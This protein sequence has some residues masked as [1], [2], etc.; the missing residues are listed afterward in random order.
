M[1]YPLP[2]GARITVTCSAS[3]SG[4]AMPTMQM[5][6]DH[7]NIGYIVS[8]DRRA[9]TPS[10]SYSY[11]AGDVA[12]APPLLFHRT[13]PESDA[14]YDRYLIK[15]S[16][17]LLQPLR[18]QADENIIDILY[19]ERVCRF[20]EASR[21]KIRG[22]F[23]EMYEEYS[24]GRSYTELILQGMLSRL[25]T[26]IW[27]E[28]L[29][30]DSA[31]RYPTKLTEPIVESLYFMETHY[32]RSLTLEKLAARAHLSPAY[33]SRLFS[34]QLGK[35]FSEYLAEIRLRHVQTLLARSNKTVTDIAME[36]G[37][38]SGDYLSTQ[39]KKRIGMTPSEYRRMVKSGILSAG[40]TS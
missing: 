27:E 40:S 29:P 11:H 39:F 20:N 1:P 6:T 9:V 19:D 3:D 37:Y 24:K 2:A 35:S 21:T 31:F 4:Y 15:F 22:M 18:E 30:A 26:T 17:D 14:P 28:R 16:P 23:R 25:F 8:G 13:V 5:A 10:C 34:A 38:C 32:A 33:F 36:T 12:M 7:Y